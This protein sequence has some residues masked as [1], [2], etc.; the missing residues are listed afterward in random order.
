MSK[1]THQNSTS[2]R[3]SL[4]SI[5]NLLLRQ[6]KKVEKEI[7]T[8]DSEDPVMESGGLA[9]ASE[10]GTESW[11]ADAHSRA[12]SVKNSLQEILDKTK[13]ALMAL[14]KG[15]YGKCENCGKVIESERLK[16]MPAAIFCV[17]C[18]KIKSK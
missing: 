10:S 6:K 1:L 12:V 11:L 13:K 14:S 9:E 2:S 18:S 4:Q 5:K 17:D 8:V 16:A 15:K 3:F 7:K